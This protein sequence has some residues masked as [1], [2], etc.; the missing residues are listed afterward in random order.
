MNFGLRRRV[1][2]RTA[3]LLPLLLVAAMPPSFA[4]EPSLDKPLAQIESAFLTHKAEPLTTLMPGEG[5]I[6]L[7]FASLGG[8]VGYFSRDQVYFILGGIFTRYQTIDFTIKPQK[9]ASVSAEKPRPG[10]G[11]SYCVGMWSFHKR[12]GGGRGENQIFFVLSMR[13]GVW[14]LVEIR[15]AQ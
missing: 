8:G 3:R 13:K 6:Y 2:A 10:S 12:D 11:L 15:E 9:T 14:S 5:K 1:A 4:A 7:S